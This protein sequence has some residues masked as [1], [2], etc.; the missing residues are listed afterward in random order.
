MSKKNCLIST[1]FKDNAYL[2]FTFG[3]KLEK[4]QSGSFFMS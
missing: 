3:R 1:N 4:I 2:L